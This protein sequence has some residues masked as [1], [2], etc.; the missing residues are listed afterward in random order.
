MT[1]YSIRE[2]TPDDVAVIRRLVLE[3]AVYE[4]L[5]HEMIASDELFGEALFGPAKCAEC[6]LADV[7]QQSIG[8]ALFF[9][10]FSTF[11]GR[12]GI[13]LE[14]LFVKPEFRGHGIGKALLTRVAELAVERNCGR[15]EWSVLN[16]NRPSIEFYQKL[17]AVPMSGWTVYRLTGEALHK[18]GIQNEAT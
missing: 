15:L 5:E 7:E 2:A 4:R 18:L 1:A 9:T 8:L 14:D 10:N 6:L 12:P 17:G 16:W 11:L 13:Y 3:L